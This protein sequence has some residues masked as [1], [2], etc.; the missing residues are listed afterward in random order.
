[1]KD[2]TFQRAETR[3]DD[4]DNEREEESET[5]APAAEDALEMMKKHSTL[6]MLTP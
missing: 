1:M 6:A 2:K 3:A 4:S 5:D